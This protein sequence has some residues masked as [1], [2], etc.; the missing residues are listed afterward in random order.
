MFCLKHDCFADCFALFTESVLEFPLY[1]TLL[2]CTIIDAVMY[3]NKA[4]KKNHFLLLILKYCTVMHYCVIYCNI[5]YSNLTAPFS[6][7][8]ARPSL[9]RSVH[10]LPELPIYDFWSVDECL[11]RNR[12]HLLKEMQ[13]KKG[14][15][16]IYIYIFFVC[17]CVCVKNYATSLRRKKRKK[18]LQKITQPYNKKERFFLR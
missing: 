11:V 5:V 1:H 8:G 13:F 16:D 4:K 12:R 10:E 2:Y 15:G 18:I 6:N 17:V 14:G 3:L 7:Y 9:Q